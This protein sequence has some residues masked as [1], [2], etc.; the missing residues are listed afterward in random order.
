M[1]LSCHYI[2]IVTILYSLKSWSEC[3]CQ[4]NN[5]GDDCSKNAFEAVQ[6]QRL[7]ESLCVNLYNTIGIE[8]VSQDVVYKRANLLSSM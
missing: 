5:N 8:D 2:L 4:P 3:V 7:R 1:Y 6:D